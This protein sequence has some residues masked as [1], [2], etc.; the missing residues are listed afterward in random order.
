[1][2]FKRILS[3]LWAI[4][5]VIGC[6]K[7]AV[8]QLHTMTHAHDVHC[9]TF[10]DDG[11]LM[12][13]G[14]LHNERTQEHPGDDELRALVLK[15]GGDEQQ[16]ERLTK[17]GGEINLWDVASGNLLRTLHGHT[18]CVCAVD[19]SPDGRTL[20]T[21]NAILFGVRGRDRSCEVKLW[22]VATGK[23]RTTLTGHPDSVRSIAFSRDGKRLASASHDGTVII[24]NVAE[25]K[26]LFRFDVQCDA[27]WKLAYFPDGKLLAIAEQRGSITF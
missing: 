20:A 19:F 22:D 10:S 26:P 14:S 15:R 4:L 3:V 16:A 18:D 24:W 17:R 2:N 6:V 5:T 23:A 27:V 13:T 12:A 21:A 11:R 9:V 7:T 25:A 1:M 8:A